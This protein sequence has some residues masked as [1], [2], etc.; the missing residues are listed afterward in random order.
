[1]GG[2]AGRDLLSV[3]GEL[4]DVGQLGDVEAGGAGAQLEREQVGRPAGVKAEA[5]QVADRA[6][7]GRAALLQRSFERA[8]ATPD[9]SELPADAQLAHH[10]HQAGAAASG[11]LDQPGRQVKRPV[12]EWDAN[13]RG[14][15]TSPIGRS[16][17]SRYTVP[18]SRPRA[19]STASSSRD[20]QGG[21]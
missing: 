7:A 18:S 11:V 20:S 19:S 13:P 1:M 17:C 2:Q 21:R 14:L 5:G 6:A 15:A 10:C 4:V 3:V 8:G 9:A 12:L 16:K